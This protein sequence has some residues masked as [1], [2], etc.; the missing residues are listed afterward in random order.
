MVYLW[1][2]IIHFSC[3]IRRERFSTLTPFRLTKTERRPF[4]NIGFSGG[5]F[6]LAAKTD[7]QKSQQ[8]HRR[9]K[10]EECSTPEKQSC[11][12]KTRCNGCHAGGNPKKMV[13][14]LG[15]ASI[16]PGNAISAFGDSCRFN[17][18]HLQKWWVTVWAIYLTVFFDWSKC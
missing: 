12:G 8:G 2:V 11:V 17:V 6:P 5:S 18:G 3:S 1:F 14:N 15:C 16:F 4:L 10:T 7:L 13:H 9:G